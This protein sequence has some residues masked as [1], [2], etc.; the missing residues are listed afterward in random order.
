MAAA[1]E[2]KPQV[3]LLLNM[4]GNETEAKETDRNFRRV[5]EKY[6]EYDLDVIGYVKNDD[7]VRKAVSALAPLM[8]R[9]PGCTAA[10][11]I[12]AIAQR[13]AGQQEFAFSAGGLR[14][15]FQKL[16]ARRRADGMEG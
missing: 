14:G 13:Y 16:T 1:L 8:V 7:E 5:V 12:E 6:L 4:V 2:D 10:R 9:N 3:R 15:L 11:Q